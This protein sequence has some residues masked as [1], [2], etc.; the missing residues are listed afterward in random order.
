MIGRQI[1]AMS[2]LTNAFKILMNNWVLAIP[3]AVASLIFML[4]LFF[5]IFAAIGSV[6][7]A[8]ALGGLHPG[9]AMAML[10][11]FGI[12][13][14]VLLILAILIALVANASVIAASEGVWQG[15][16]ADLSGGISRAIGKL[17]HLIVAAILIFLLAIIPTL[18]AIFV[19][20]I[21]LLIALGFFMMYVFP[22][23]MVGNEGGASSLGASFRLAKENFGPSA[24]AFVG[25]VV[26]LVIGNIINTIFS[27]V[28]GLNFI[29]AFVVGGLTSAYAALV[30]VRFY[31][32]LRGSAVPAVG[33]PPP[34]PT[35]NP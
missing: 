4:I 31:D 20:G 34:L 19:I 11:G 35:S 10:G 21:F 9:G 28:I 5:T 6:V 16:P 22:S 8:G 3:T 12:L 30:S 15:R 7:G 13:G 27:H 32:L 1:D 29:I 26:V 24:L 17:P 25:I 14:T 2:E 18:L 33:T 23:I